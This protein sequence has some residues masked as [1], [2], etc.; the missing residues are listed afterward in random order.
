MN[1]GNLL[2]QQLI[3]ALETLP[4]DKLLAVLRFVANLQREE[5]RW[6][7]AAS[8]AEPEPAGDPLLGFAGG[9]SHGALAHDIDEALYG[10]AP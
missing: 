8:A 7:I 10:D 2:K 1:T 3:P 5:Q 6:P 9:V 4:E